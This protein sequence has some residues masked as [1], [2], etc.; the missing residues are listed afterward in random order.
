MATGG[1]DAGADAGVGTSSV[2]AT[3]GS[4]LPS[5]GVASLGLPVYRESGD[6][7]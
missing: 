2:A 5:R 4:A 6:A 1:T 3:T 7:D